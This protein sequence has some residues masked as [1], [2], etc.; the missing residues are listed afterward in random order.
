MDTETESQAEA[1]KMQQGFLLSRYRPAAGRAD[2]F[3]SNVPSSTNAIGTVKG[4]VN[5]RN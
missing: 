2:K 1:T 3:A 5:E 4:A